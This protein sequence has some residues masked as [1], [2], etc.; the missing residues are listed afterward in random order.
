MVKQLYDFEYLPER[1]DTLW[2]ILNGRRNSLSSYAFNDIL[3][4]IP[5]GTI[6][7]VHSVC[8][9]VGDSFD[10]QPMFTLFGGK[11]VLCIRRIVTRKNILSIVLDK[12]IEYQHHG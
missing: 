6:I 2:L 1:D 3:N 7:K 9:G 12:T 10:E 5:R 11:G 8:F 4:E